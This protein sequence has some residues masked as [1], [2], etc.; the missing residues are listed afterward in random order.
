MNRKGYTAYSGTNSEVL[1]VRLK[2]VDY[3]ITN[4]TSVLSRDEIKPII[5]EKIGHY[6]NISIFSLLK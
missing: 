1:A 4:D 3:F 6:K 2:G 5:N